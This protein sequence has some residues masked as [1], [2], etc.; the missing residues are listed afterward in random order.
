MMAVRAAA[1]GFLTAEGKLSVSGHAALD[2]LYANQAIDRVAMDLLKATDGK[3][4]PDQLA[5]EATK[6]LQAILP[7]IAPNNLGSGAINDLA[8][9]TG[10]AVGLRTMGPSN[11]PTTPAQY[12]RQMHPEDRADF[13][14]LADEAR[15]KGMAEFFKFTQDF[16]A[17]VGQPGLS[18]LLVEESAAAPVAPRR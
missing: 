2:E 5:A 15:H 8:K 12:A 3:A 17:K 6:K 18:R 4:T 13:L 7:T 1:K 10:D 9:K 14:R 11:V 16:D